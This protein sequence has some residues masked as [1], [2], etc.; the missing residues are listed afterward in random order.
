M[1]RSRAT[2]FLLL[3]CAFVAHAAP[4]Q[5]TS[6]V[7]PIIRDKCLK[8]HQQERMEDGKKVEPKAG[9]RLDG[10]LGFILGGGDGAV[11]IP[12]KPKESSLFWMVTLRKGD[13]DIMPPKGEPLSKKQRYIIGKWIQEG[14]KFGSWRGNNKG[15]PQDAKN[16]RPVTSSPDVEPFTLVADSKGVAGL[17]ARGASVS[18]RPESRAKSRKRLIIDFA[19][20][21]EKIE[22]SA[23]A[24]LGALGAE[25]AE[26]NLGRTAVG[27]EAMKEVGKLTRLEWLNLSRTGVKD[28]GFAELAGLTR[29]RYLNLYGVQI[30]DKSLPVIAKMKQ[31]R[32]VYLWQSQVTPKGAAQLQRALPRTKIV[33]D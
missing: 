25:V 9:L 13:E 21:S 30:T 17:K 10:T 24:G 1:R 29:L 11:V 7:L 14:A 20:E 12:G 32:S 19:S 31:L 3:G 23:L 16:P 33:M 4:I 27:N 22:D 28:E 18:V 2:I 6:Q 26:L 15:F 5:F 8:C